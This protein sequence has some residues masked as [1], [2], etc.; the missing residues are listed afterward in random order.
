MFMCCP[1]LIAAGIV[2]MTPPG[3]WL[4]MIVIVVSC[5]VWL[6]LIE[7]VVDRFYFVNWS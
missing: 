5:G 3:G 6:G 2:F 4:H 1:L 7:T